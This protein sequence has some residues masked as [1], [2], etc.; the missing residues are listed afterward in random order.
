M[1]F[2]SSYRTLPGT[3]KKGDRLENINPLT[4]KI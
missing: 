1:N 3:A 2:I 4:P